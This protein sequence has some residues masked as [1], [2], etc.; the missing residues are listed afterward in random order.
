MLHWCWTRRD[1]SSELR[2][3]GID[4][5][6]QALDLASSSLLQHC[7]LLLPTNVD[8]ICAHYLDGLKAARARCV[9]ALL[10]TGHVSACPSAADTDCWGSLTLSS[11]YSSVQACC[12]VSDEGLVGILRPDACDSRLQRPLDVRSV[13]RPE[14]IIHIHSCYVNLRSV[15]MAHGPWGLQLTL[16]FA[17]RYPE[18]HLCILWLGSSVGNLSPDETLGFFKQVLEICGPKSQVI[19]LI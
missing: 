9:F 19:L 3:V 1:G 10:P 2:F 17:C 11:A 8:L 13:L 7:P 18:A 5:S 16:D 15:G 4:V 12:S 6:Q 14:N